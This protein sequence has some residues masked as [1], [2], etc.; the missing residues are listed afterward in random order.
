MVTCRR[1]PVRT[2]LTI[3][4]AAGEGTRMRSSRPKVLHAIAGRSLLAHVLAAVDSGPGAATAVVIGP[5]Q[6]AVATEIGRL[7]P[8]AGPLPRSAFARRIRPATV[9]YWSHPERWS[10]FARTRMRAHGNARLHCAM[11]D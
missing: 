2:C 11:P 10:P 9:G 7:A 3:A 1:P 5:D 4:L 6:A 8:T